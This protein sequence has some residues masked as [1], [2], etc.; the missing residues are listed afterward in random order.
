MATADAR[1]GM[2]LRDVGDD[3][4]FAAVLFDTLGG[5]KKKRSHLLLIR[6][7]RGCRSVKIRP[8]LVVVLA[9][10][11]SRNRFLVTLEECLPRLTVRTLKTELD[12]EILFYVGVAFDQGVDDSLRLPSRE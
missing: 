9:E 5:A 12:R 3:R 10:K 11:P 1:N 2:K 6:N 8:E 4:R 7:L